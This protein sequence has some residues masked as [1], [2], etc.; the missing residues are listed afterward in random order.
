MQ[1]LFTFFSAKILACQPYLIIKVL[2]IC[3]L[4]DTLTNT[5]DSFEQLGPGNDL[6]GADP[7]QIGLNC[8]LRQANYTLRNGTKQWTRTKL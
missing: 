8:W 2:M 3:Q 5:I 1:K 4:T 7:N 6:K